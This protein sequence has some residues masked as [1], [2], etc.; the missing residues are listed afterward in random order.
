MNKTICLDFDG[1][2]HSYTSGWQGIS[3][4]PD[5]PTSGCKET[6]N[7]LRNSG[8]KVVVHS[9]RCQT[10]EGRDAIENYLSTHGIEV[11]GVCEHKPA[12]IIYIDDRAIQF[13][14]NWDETMTSISKFDHWLGFNNV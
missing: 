2:I 1:V 7:L 3:I 4:I 13:S 11:D 6:I 10:Q 9:T 12:A 14:G 5:P 8:H